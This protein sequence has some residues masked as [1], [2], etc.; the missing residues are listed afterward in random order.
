M[1]R[2]I[3]EYVLQCLRQDYGVSCDWRNVVVLESSSPTKFSRHLIFDTPGAIFRALDDAGRFVAKMVAQLL[4]SNGSPR[5]NGSPEPEDVVRRAAAS[6]LQVLD[7]NQAA[8]YF[9]DTGIYTPNRTFRLFLSRKLGKQYWLTLAPD[10]ELAVHGDTAEARAE[11][12]FQRSLLVD[13]CHWQSSDGSG[14]VVDG[15]SNGVRI[16]T[17]G[18][19]GSSSGRRFDSSGRSRGAASNDGPR[20]PTEDGAT[21]S[22]ANAV[23]I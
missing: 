20:P 11:F 1:S 18:T 16:L 21:D 14:P 8:A 4:I 5:G 2:A 19:R 13:R 12:V 7:E 22:G 23:M 3:G 9:I 6:A 10:C 17:C 15:E